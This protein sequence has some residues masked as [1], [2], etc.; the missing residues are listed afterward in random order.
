MAAHRVRL[1]DSEKVSRL[2]LAVSKVAKSLHGKRSRR[3]DGHQKTFQYAESLKRGTIRLFQIVPSDDDGETISCTLTTIKLKTKPEFTAISYAWGNLAETRPINLNG[4]QFMVTNNLYAL[5]STLRKEKRP[6][7]FWVDAV[8]IN[9]H[10]D[11]TEKT[12]QVRQMAN[13]YTEARQVLAWLGEERPGDIEA[14]DAMRDLNSRILSTPDDVSLAVD[15]FNQMIWATYTPAWEQICALLA[16]DWFWRGWVIQ[17]FL[18]ARSCTFRC[19]HLILDPAV[20]QDFVA[21]C[22]KYLDV[23]S[24]LSGA[25]RNLLAPGESPFTKPYGP[26]LV[27]RTNETKV[28]SLPVLITRMSGAR[29][30]DSRDRLFALVGLSARKYNGL[31]DYGKGLPTALLRLAKEEM[32]QPL[33]DRRLDILRFNIPEEPLDGV[34]SWVPRFQNPGYIYPM[35]SFSWITSF[36]I[37]P[38]KFSFGEDYVRVI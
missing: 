35:P 3:H 9:Q 28:H 22:Y 15:D 33:E 6:E 34:P 27:L 30:T 25:K 36:P 7:L 29:F 19:G 21:N 11:D 12:G 24:M 20:F 2:Q 31:V 4:K 26:A 1:L 38:P 5:L 13:I 10:S 14:Y 18:F 23:D 32:Q 16:K 8:C 37:A 17:E